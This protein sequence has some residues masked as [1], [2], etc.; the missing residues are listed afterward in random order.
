E[1]EPVSGTEDLVDVNFDVTE[2]PAGTLQFGVGY[3]DSEG[4]LINGS[5]THNNFL[6]TGNRVSLGAETNDYGQSVKTSWTDPYFTEDGVSRT[7]SAYYRET[8]QLISSSDSGF[9]MTSMGTAMTFGVPL[10]EY[11]S[12]RLGLG[13]DYDEITTDIYDND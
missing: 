11:S 7:V 13:V 2:R 9:D 6:G 5:V 4:F 12:L 1:T 3:S 10:S 8:D